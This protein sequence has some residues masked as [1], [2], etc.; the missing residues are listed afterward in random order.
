M[1]VALTDEE[2]AALLRERKALPPDYRTRIEARP[3]RGHK[4]RELDVQGDAGNRFRL[5]IRQGAVDPFDFSII[6]MYCPAGTNQVFRLRRYNGRS[7][8]HTNRIEGETFYA[9]H[10]HMATARYQESGMR[11]DSY[12]EASDRFADVAGAIDCMLADCG[13]D[14][15]NLQT[16]LFDEGAAP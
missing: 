1:T 5:V 12:A 7:H 14:R 9:F 8:E 16:T 10:I 4:E 13:F 11:E 15:T 2:I 3:K 6:L